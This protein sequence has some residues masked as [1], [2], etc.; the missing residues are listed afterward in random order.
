MIGENVKKNEDIRP[1]SRELEKLK[2]NFPQ[3]FSK[4]GEF[5]S[6]LFNK[7]LRQ[8]EV[9]ITKEGYEL[10][11]LGKSFARYL[12]GLETETYLAPDN[13][14]NQEEINKNSENLY[15][16]G[17]NI[18]GLRHLL[19]SY[20]GK[21]KCIY[22]D[23]PYNTGT[24]GFVYP[25]KFEFKVGELSN[26]IGISNEEAERILNLEGKSNHSAWLTFMYPRLVLA[27]DLLAEDGVIFISIDDNEQANLKLMCDEIF[28][29]ENLVSDGAVIVKTEG[30]RYGGF[31]KTH[32]YFYSYAKSL[33]IFNPNEITIEGK[34]FEFE[35]AY[36]G[37]NIQDLRNQNARAF[38]ETNRPNLRYPFYVDEKNPDS[39]NFLKVSLEPKEGY[40]EVYPIITNEYK[41]VWRW[42]K[43]ENE[44]ARTDFHNICARKGTDSIIRIFEKMR[45]IKEKPKTVLIGKE[46]LSNKG[47]KEVA[48]LLG[49]GIFD[50]PKPLG[51]INTFINIGS[52]KESLILDFFS[53]SST[54]ADAVMQLNAEDGGNRKY[55][56]VQLPEEIE[57]KKP[58]Y[59]AGYRTIDE[60]GRERIKRAGAKIKEETG[61]DIDYGFKLYRIEE[62][63]DSTLSML[64]NFDPVTTMRLDDMVGIFD[65]KYSKGKDAILATWLNEDGY[66][67]TRESQE[68]K[69]NDY[70]ANL[71]DGSLYIIDKGLR[72]EDVMT[73]INRLEDGSLNIS[74]V[75]IYVHSIDFTV[76]QELRKNIKVLKNNKD[77]SL[78]E[79]F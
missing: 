47:T 79:R 54:T 72:S 48:E 44:K 11:F 65:N 62:P 17:D 29:E 41:S 59:K 51:L 39:N 35:D 43:G 71:I 77:V 60:I 78:I 24:D 70:A 36:G 33:N 49:E 63:D 53:G 32:D 38:N 68:Y 37:F 18:D 15:I 9:E 61:A 20:A 19:N 66:G 58:A 42:G 3:F 73:L 10:N 12:S 28:G 30:R 52:N 69:L 22:I 6:D 1:N 2:E 5:K 21:V 75:V 55:I 8:E 23:P 34:S 45:N 67:L 27:R 13:K 40:I 74:R 57:E 76:L 4:K 14:H 25:D 56:M 31:A 7:F 26:L 64:E 46:Y 50:F 16:V